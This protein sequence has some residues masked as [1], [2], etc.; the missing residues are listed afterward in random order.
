MCAQLPNA[1]AGRECPPNSR[2]I[3]CTESISR[4][5]RGGRTARNANTI[6]SELACPPPC[7]DSRPALPKSN[8]P[9]RRY[10]SPKAHGRRLFQ[11]NPATFSYIRKLIKLSGPS[12]CPFSVLK[13][14]L[15]FEE[16]G[17]A[18]ICLYIE[19]KMQ[20]DQ[21]MPSSQGRELSNLCSRM[22]VQDVAARLSC[23]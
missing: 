9:Y 10:T 1:R 5:R 3:A 23:C 18:R 19:F 14:T 16:C 11:V 17:F 4:R 13:Q 2:K 8:E 22:S 15:L 7:A 12:K 20:L 21:G 6:G